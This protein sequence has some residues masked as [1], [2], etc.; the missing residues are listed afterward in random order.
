M[1]LVP[2]PP[3]AGLPRQRRP[4]VAA[5]R[6]RARSVCLYTCSFNP[7]G[8]GAHMLALAEQYVAAGLDVSVAFWPAPAAES[9]MARAADLGATLLRTPHPRHPA[10]AETLAD[11]LRLARP[12]VVHVHVG[13]G[14]EDFGGARV[15]K[16]AGVPVVVQTLHLPWLLRD[17]RRIP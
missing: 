17:T 3:S 15:A 13:T 14:R 5:G 1:T 6:R 7:S 9:L 2:A 8:M 11:L 16:H 12:D 10:Y 4:R